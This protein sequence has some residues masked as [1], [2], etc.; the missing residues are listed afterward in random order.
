M[1]LTSLAVLLVLLLAAGCGGDDSSFT[2]DYN[3]AVRPLRQLGSGMGTQPRAFERLARG[4]SRTRANLAKLD[5]PDDAQDELD[6]LLARLDDVTADLRGVA[7]AERSDDVVKQRRAARALVRS[8]AA[9]QGAET[10]LKRA[11]EG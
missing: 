9:V 8:S 6:T 1:K 4:T 2:A 5:A 10:A 3:K 7:S 11:V